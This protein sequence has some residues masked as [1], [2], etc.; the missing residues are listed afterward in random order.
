MFGLLIRSMPG[1]GYALVTKYTVRWNRNVR[2][3]TS[4]SSAPV[5]L[6]SR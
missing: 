3:A 6:G 4:A 2:Y 1:G 5:V